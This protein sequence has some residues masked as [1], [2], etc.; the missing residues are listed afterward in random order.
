MGEAALATCADATE[1]TLTMPNRHHL[2]VDLEPF[3]LDNPKEV[4]VATDQP[5]DSWKQTIGVRRL[6]DARTICSWASTARYAGS[7]FSRAEEIMAPDLSTTFTGVRFQNPSCR[8]RRRRIKSNILRAFEA[9]WGG[10]VTKTIVPGRQRLGPKTV[11]SCRRRFG[12]S[13]DEEAPWRCAAFVVE[14]GAHLRQTLDCGCRARA[15]SGVSET[16]A[17]G[18]HHGLAPATTRS[19]GTGRNSRWRVPG[20]DALS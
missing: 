12:A 2:L 20:C 4:F 13:V 19:C 6:S 15:A 11:P 9:G 18:V 7:D 3:G 8:R 10:V 14:L 17:R 5:F 16:R 1:I